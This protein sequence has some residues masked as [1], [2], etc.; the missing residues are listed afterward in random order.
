MERNLNLHLNVNFEKLQNKFQTT[1]RLVSV[2]L[3]F[4]W[5]DFD[6]RIT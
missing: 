2:K 6:L 3:I 1:V 5:L 4:Q